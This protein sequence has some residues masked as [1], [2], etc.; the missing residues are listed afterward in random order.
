MQ[1]QTNTERRDETVDAFARLLAGTDQGERQRLFARATKRAAN[2]D[3][4][5]SLPI[6]EVMSL[7]EAA[8]DTSPPPLLVP[9]VV[10]EG[11]ITWLAGHPAHGKT[12]V[13][14]HAALTAIRQGRPV[15]WIDWEGGKRPTARR[16]AAMGAT[17]ED[18]SCLH[19]SPFPRLTADRNGLDVVLRRLEEMP[20]ALVV[21]DSA[22][23]A[24]AAAGLDENSTPDATKWTTE[25][26]M[27]LREVATVI[28]IDHVPKSAT[29]T[30][31]YPRGAGSK[32][33]DTEVFW[34]VE[35]EEKFSREQI[36]RVLLTLHK[37]RE[38]ILPPQGVRFEV[39][40]GAGK[41]PVKQIPVDDASGPSSARKAR[42]AVLDVLRRHDGE[43][44]TGRQ[45]TELVGG[46][47]ATAREAL[48]DLA[49]DPSAPV[50]ARP[51][52]KNAVHYRFNADAMT[53]LEV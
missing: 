35:A 23:K 37:D 11:L 46:K 1:E 9:D 40:D 38:G 53:A 4:E 41:L 52:E 25:V 39:G 15:L 3:V 22:S 33:A 30:T 27:P 18:F 29:R 48:R 31:P 17:E 45:I 20:G 8:A 49:A 5:V 43:E 26:V 12:T 44:L 21:F 47:A 34:Y 6:L 42:D 13:A 32:L 14:M 19:Y 50:S 7:A 16:L 28:V 24:L 51:G 2:E 36:G 10:P